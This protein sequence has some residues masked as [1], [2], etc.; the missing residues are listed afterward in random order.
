M[1]VE[2]ALETAEN[3][4]LKYAGIAKVCR[5]R[6]TLLLDRLPPKHCKGIV[7]RRRVFDPLDVVSLRFTSSFAAAD[8]H[9]GAWTVHVVQE[10]QINLERQIWSVNT[11]ESESGLLRQSVQVQVRDRAN[12]PC[13]H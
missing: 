1:A 7:N 2:T 13:Q 8:E 12:P 4:N 11:I 3:S 9:Y 5:S 6:R 10:C